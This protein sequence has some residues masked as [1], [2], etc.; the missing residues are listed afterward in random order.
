MHAW[1]LD[2]HG[3]VLLPEMP[4][5]WNLPGGTPKDIKC[6]WHATLNHE[7][8][9]KADVTLR[10]VFPLGYQEVRPEG[11]QPYAQLRVAA[12]VDRWL[13]ATPDPDN[14]QVYP[15]VWAPLSEA[16]ERL[17]WGKPGHT[18]AATAAQFTLTYYGFT[19]AT[20][21]AQGD[22]AGNAACVIPPGSRQS[23]GQKRSDPVKEVG[24]LL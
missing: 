20:P 8:A 9:E 7:V 17:G 11:G 24:T 19:A 1:N 4:G 10:A 21:V 3:R 5:G 22:T 16:A 2:E 18:Q 15:R 6:D 23:L 13:P 12:R 14:G